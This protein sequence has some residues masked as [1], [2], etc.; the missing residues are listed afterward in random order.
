MAEDRLDP[1]R[2]HVEVTERTFLDEQTARHGIEQLRA[3]GVGVA[4]DDFGIGYS[5]L[6]YLI[7][8]KIDRLKIDR[9][10]I[11]NI[12]DSSANQAMVGAMVGFAGGYCCWC[13]C[14]L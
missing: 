3:I 1:S 13:C 12:S 9:S 7:S 5:S 6:A 11:T 10:I 8:L 2:I 4:I 14:V